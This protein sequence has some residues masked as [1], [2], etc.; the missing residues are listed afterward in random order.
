ML[1][2]FAKHAEIE[3]VEEEWERIGR[4]ALASFKFFVIVL[5]SMLHCTGSSV[6]WRGWLSGSRC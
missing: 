1:G 6:C 2:M 5:Y 4:I 3:E